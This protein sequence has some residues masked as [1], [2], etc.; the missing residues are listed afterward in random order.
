M[1]SGSVNDL[2]IQSGPAPKAERER[3]TSKWQVN[4]N[5]GNILESSS[6]FGRSPRHLPRLYVEQQEYEMKLQAKQNRARMSPIYN[7]D[8]NNNNGDDDESTVQLYETT[9][10]DDCKEDE[11]E[12][13]Y[14]DAATDD[15]NDV[16]NNDSCN[17][18][19]N[20]NETHYSQHK[21][22]D[23]NFEMPSPSE[24][25]KVTDMFT[26]PMATQQFVNN[27][28]K[29]LR[30]LEMQKKINLE[31][32]Q[33]S[34]EQK[35]ELK[36][37]RDQVSISHRTAAS[38]TA[39]RERIQQELRSLADSLENDPI[40]CFSSSQTSRE[41][42]PKADDEES[43]QHYRDQFR[44]YQEDFKQEKEDKERLR[45]LNLKLTSELEEAKREI[46]SYQKK[47]LVYAQIF[48]NTPPA[49][50]VIPPAYIGRRVHSSP[51]TP[52]SIN[53]YSHFPGR[54]PHS[55]AAAQPD[56][57]QRRAVMYDQYSELYG[58]FRNISKNELCASIRA[59]IIPKGSFEAT[60]EG[61]SFDEGFPVNQVPS[62]P[63]QQPPSQ[64]RELFR[65]RSFSVQI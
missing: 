36:F 48:S 22:T 41:I 31:L 61:F 6:V 25:D 42:T 30:E 65:K 38:E 14:A 21:S 20:R 3:V 12:C 28:Y 43:I 2:T 33:S 64:E 9:K 34:N 24:K 5:D 19:H 17:A 51:T 10:L 26:E 37:L 58:S 46:E 1:L 29:L 32:C 47:L 59:D 49:Q 15:P 27:Y 18:D 13:R 53:G 54:N 40:T 45:V 44:I 7:E 8:N 55:Q 60:Q 50:T 57:F 56:A 62:N 63:S 52:S 16:K 11:L 23:S 4:N 35:K 39:V